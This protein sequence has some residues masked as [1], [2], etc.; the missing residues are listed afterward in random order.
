M[1]KKYVRDV[2]LI[3]PPIGNGSIA[4]VKN[5]THFHRVVPANIENG[6]RS[7]RSSLASKQ[8]SPSVR[9][10]PTGVAGRGHGVGP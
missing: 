10:V 2:V 6:S 8:N 7:E 5:S 4:H 9:R 1:D 3:A